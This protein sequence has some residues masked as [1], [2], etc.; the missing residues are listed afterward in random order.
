[1]FITC[2][3]RCSRPPYSDVYHLGS[4]RAHQFIRHT[5]RVHFHVRRGVSRH[6]HY[7]LCWLVLFLVVSNV[8]TVHYP[9]QGKRF[10]LFGYY[11]YIGHVFSWSTLIFDLP[12]V[13]ALLPLGVEPFIMVARTQTTGVFHRHLVTVIVFDLLRALRQHNGIFSRPTQSKFVMAWEVRLERS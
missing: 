13:T 3:C 10:M 12:I 1:M 9:N 11:T 8:L 6:M 2:C 7:R 5:P 4:A